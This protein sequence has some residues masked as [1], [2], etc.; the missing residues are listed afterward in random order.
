MGRAMNAAVA[1]HWGLRARESQQEPEE[2]YAA[3]LVLGGRGSGKT[4]A[5]AGWVLDRAW[6]GGRIALIGPS[7]HDVREVTGAWR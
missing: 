1:Q 7:L 6:A 2:N 4:F 3:W 5:G